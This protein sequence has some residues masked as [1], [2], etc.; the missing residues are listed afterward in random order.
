MAGVPLLTLQG[1]ETAAECRKVECTVIMPQG[2]LLN[3][4]VSDMF[5]MRTSNLHEL[6][7]SNAQRGFF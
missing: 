3:T 7:V 6:M 2:G 5:W 1:K 4:I